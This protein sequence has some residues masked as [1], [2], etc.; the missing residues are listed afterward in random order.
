VQVPLEIHNHKKK[1]IEPLYHRSP[2]TKKVL[3]TEVTAS[4]NREVYGNCT[5]TTKQLATT[6]NT[7]NLQNA[8]VVPCPYTKTMS[9]HY[10]RASVV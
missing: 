7:H 2:K 5:Y 10:L 3:V 6:L 8:Q 9:Q 1:T 4:P